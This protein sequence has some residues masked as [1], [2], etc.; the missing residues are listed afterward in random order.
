MVQY[1]LVT[2]KMKILQNYVKNLIDNEKNFLAVNNEI[3]KGKLNDL[4]VINMIC[5]EKELNIY[6]YDAILYL[7]SY[8]KKILIKN[9]NKVNNNLGTRMFI[10]AL[11]KNGIPYTVTLDD[12]ELLAKKII[13]LGDSLNIYLYGEFIRDSH[14]DNNFK[15]KISKLLVDGI[16]KASI[17]IHITMFIENIINRLEI[18][19]ICKE[20]L[21]YTL[22][23]SILQSKNN[24]IIAKFLYC[25]NRN[26]TYFNDLDKLYVYKNI[27]RKL[28][29]NNNKVIMV[30]FSYLDFT[31]EEINELGKLILDTQNIFFIYCFTRKFTQFN[32]D[33]QCEYV[34]FLSN[35]ANDYDKLSGKLQ[36][37]LLKSHN[38][39]K[40]LKRN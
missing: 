12:L 3:T 11:C 16:G 38:K 27:I 10:S 25:I 40:I 31:K 14:L 39:S 34:E 21:K 8:N 19:E 24:E 36:K 6:I 22:I 1:L 17:F 30:N 9:I 32:N 23:D 33:L 35:Y 5:E 20:N 28:V 13:E 37:I 2:Q 4:F 29:K 18:N 26:N 15:L 7:H